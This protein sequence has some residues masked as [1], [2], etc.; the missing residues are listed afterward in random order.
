MILLISLLDFGLGILASLIASFTFLFVVLWFLRPKVRI[1]P[2]ICK[3][4]SPYPGEGEMYFIKVVNCSWFSAYDVRADLIHIQKFEMPP[5]A[6]TNRRLTTL[7]MKKATLSYIPFA[8]PKWYR[9]EAAHCMI[10]RTDEDLSGLLSQERNIVEFQV[11]LRH[12]LTGFAKLH[13]QEYCDLSEIRAG[14][15]TYGPKFGV[16]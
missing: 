8:A 14:K 1:A 16:L 15:Y 10:L 6:S 9:R 3:N 7:N 13:K 4:Q 11:T 12:G 2:F 5:N